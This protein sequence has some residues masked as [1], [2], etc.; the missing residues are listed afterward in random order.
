MTGLEGSEVTLLY[1]KERDQIM[2]S[3]G[4]SCEGSELKDEILALVKREIAAEREACA[5]IADNRPGGQQTE[6]GN[7]YDAAC[8]QIAAAIRSRGETQ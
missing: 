7:G 3:M 4:P 1:D 2:V 5:Q 8:V 6:Y